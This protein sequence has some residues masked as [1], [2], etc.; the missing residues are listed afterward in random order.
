[1]KLKLSQ[2][3]ELP[4][5]MEHSKDCIY[6]R[7]PRYFG[8]PSKEKYCDCGAFDSNL[9]LDEISNLEIDL[10]ELIDVEKVIN[11]MKYHLAEYLG[12]TYK[13]TAQ[14]IVENIGG[15]LK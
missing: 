11:I 1:M 6:V 9:T 13:E 12:H 10:S 7:E 5:K 15:C 4:E 2:V 3:V 14:A 8:N